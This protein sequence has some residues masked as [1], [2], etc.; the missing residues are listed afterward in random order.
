MALMLHCGAQE[1]AFDQLRQL[2]TP[3]PTPSHVPIPHFRLVDM[4]RHSL[5]YYGHEVVDEHHGVSEDGMRYF[6][7][8]SLKSSYG[9]Y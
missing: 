2:D 1:V 6:G 8:L 5:S 7:V 4:L 3:L 9:G